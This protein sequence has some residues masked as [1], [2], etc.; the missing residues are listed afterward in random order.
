MGATFR[1]GRVAGIPIGVHWSLVV[2]AALLTTSLAGSLLPSVVPNARGS[3]WAAAVLAAALFFASILAHELSHAIVARHFGQRVEDITLWILGGVSRLGSES[4]SPRAEA[5][6]AL[7]GPGMSLL[8]GALFFGGGHLL[9]GAEPNSLLAVVFIWLGAVNLI[10]AAF[11]LLPGAPLDGGRVVSAYLWH[12]HGDR[13]RA[14]IGA[15]RSGRVVGSALIALGLLNLVTGI[16]VGTLWTALVGFFIVQASHAEERMAAT[17]RAL[18]GVRV[19]DVMTPAPPEIPEWLTAGEV[20]NTIAPPPAPHHL[21]VLRSFDGSVHAV[22]PVD[23]IRHLP[24]EVP[25]RDAARA[26][27]VAPPDAR[28]L[29]VVEQQRPFSAIVVMDGAQVRGVIGSDEL[30]GAQRGTARVPSG[31]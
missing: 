24:P 4:P 21:M 2:I 22:V 26:A 31:R 29:D 7:A 16:G 20:R 27:V 11:N 5:L 30:E 8:L 19:R 28:V 18:E 10:L 3:Y 9:H 25:V 6:V 23:A 1:I 15:A 17:A 13:R 14:Q 12:R